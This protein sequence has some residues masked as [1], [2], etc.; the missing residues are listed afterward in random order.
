MSEENGELNIL[1]STE[2]LMFSIGNENYALHISKIKEIGSPEHCTRIPNS[3][4]FVKGVTNLRGLI[5]PIY[6]LRLKFGQPEA[7]P[8]LQS[9]VI[10]VNIDSRVVGLIVDKVLDVM[11]CKPEDIKPAPELT[12]RV[13]SRFIKGFIS[14]GDSLIILLDIDLVISLD[15]MGFID[16]AGSLIDERQ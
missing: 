11:D 16:A 2:Y 5:V 3:P 12:T 15:E 7:D 6:D 1:N 14:H 13:D 4:K 8:G 10:V 9:S